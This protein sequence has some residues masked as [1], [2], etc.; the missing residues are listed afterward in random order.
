M[1]G[2]K[3]YFN[4]VAEMIATR[5][6]ELA[7]K[8]FVYYYDEEVTYAQLNERCNRVANFL[9][10]KGV[11]KGDIVSIMVLNSPECYY[12]TFGA[13]KLGAVAGQINYMLMPPEIAYVLDDSQPKLVFVG[14]EYMTTFAKGYALA[15][16]KPIVVE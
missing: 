4:S 14:S 1:D 11:I 5:A 10:E 7:D 12:T 15:R 2:K 13:Q 9:K 6:R 16:H 3:K 8:V